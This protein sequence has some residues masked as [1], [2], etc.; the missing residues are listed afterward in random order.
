[1]ENI[2]DEIEEENLKIM[3]AIIENLKGLVTSLEKGQSTG[4]C[5]LKEQPLHKCV[6]LFFSLSGLKGRKARRRDTRENNRRVTISEE[7]S[8]A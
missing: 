1:M 8:L 4:S 3:K 7:W 5:Y 6:S 2:F